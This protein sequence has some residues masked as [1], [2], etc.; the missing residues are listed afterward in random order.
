M[1]LPR[2]DEDQ[3]TKVEITKLNKTSK[4]GRKQKVDKQKKTLFYFHT[5]P[6]GD[7]E[8]S[9]LEKSNNNYFQKHTRDSFVT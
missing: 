9:F 3:T 7:F 8:L 6:G 4:Q 1:T 5:D 2:H